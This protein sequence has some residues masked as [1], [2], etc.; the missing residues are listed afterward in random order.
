MGIV[1]MYITNRPQTA[2]SAQKY[3]VERIWI[4]LETLGKDVRQYGISSVKSHHCVEDIRSIKPLLTVSE[5]LVRVNPWHEFAYNGYSGSAEEIQAVIEAGADIV[6]LPM[7]KTPKEVSAFLEAVAGRAKTVLLLETREAEE[8]LE[9]VLSLGREGSFRIDEIHIGLNDLHIAYQK[10]FMFELLTDGTVE[11][12]CNRMKKAG[13]PYGFGGIAKIGDGVVPAEKIILEHFRLGSTRTILSRT[14]CDNAR[15][16]DAEEID[17][18]FRWNMK[19]LKEFEANA[20]HAG[21]EA[22]MQNRLELESE[23]K[24]A[25]LD[26][27]RSKRVSGQKERVVEKAIQAELVKEGTEDSREAFYLLDSRHFEQNFMELKKCFSSVY[28]HF[29]IAYS[30]KTNY[31]P[32]ICK[33]ADRLGGYAEVV[34][35]MEL[36]MAFRCG[37]DARR[38]IW[39]GPVKNRKKTEKLLCMGGTVNID[40]LQELK[41]VREIA[42]RYPDRKLYAGIRCSFDIGDGTVSRFGMD[43]HGKDFEEAL[44][45]VKNCENL[46][47]AGIHC[48]FAKRDLVYWPSRVKG[49]LEVIDRIKKTLGF[50]PGRI[51][52]GGGIYGKM[53]ESLKS[54]FKDVISGYGDYAECIRE[55]NRKFPDCMPEV[56]IEPGTA[57]IADCMKFVCR[58]KTIKNIRGR[59]FITVSGSQNNISMKG[60]NPPLEVIRLQPDAEAVCVENAVIAG[61]TCMEGDVLYQGYTGRIAPGDYVVFGNCGSYSV[62]MKPPFILEN[63]PIYDNGADGMETVKRQECFDDI[64]CTYHF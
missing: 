26:I 56:L 38:I 40:S 42:G 50:V 5:L 39:N 9:E 55:V 6:M 4:D 20:A 13:I 15:M 12:L 51:D 8:C 47:L 18:V 16:D 37:V 23:I 64:F 43:V 62:V 2:L 45:I 34:S 52:L 31:I 53:P 21:T 35:E 11:R 32:K 29:N 59:T 54:Q 33:I 44:S 10:D 27:K 36:E 14:F 19:E 49:M 30:Y 41:T 63:I 28:P 57:L 3:G 22:W 25:V 7:W 60:L 58:V 1:H 17:R 46:Q 61:Y 24:K 48:H